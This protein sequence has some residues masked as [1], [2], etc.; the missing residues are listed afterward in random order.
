MDE[1]GRALKET[2]RFE[3][4]AT[5][6]AFHCIK[7]ASFAQNEFFFVLWTNI[8]HGARF[9]AGCNRYVIERQLTYAFAEKWMLN[10]TKGFSKGSCSCG[11]G[12]EKCFLYQPA[13][14]TSSGDASLCLED[15]TKGFFYEVHHFQCVEEN[16]SLDIFAQ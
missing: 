12:R 14:G 1:H 6:G 5:L 8:H 3:A 16:I 13:A 9:G 10:K 7:I 2:G 4:M 11:N 15:A